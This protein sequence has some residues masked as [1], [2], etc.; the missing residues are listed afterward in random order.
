LLGLVVHY[1]IAEVEAGGESR[2]ELVVEKV[3]VEADLP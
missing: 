2:L 1:R 3:V